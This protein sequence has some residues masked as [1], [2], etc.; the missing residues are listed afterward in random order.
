MIAYLHGT[1]NYKSALI[2][3]DNFAVI[4]VG[5]VGYKVYI[6]DRTLNGWHLGDTVE[7]HV[8]TQVGEDVLDL[9]GFATRDEMDWF[10]LLIGISGIGPRSAL[11]ILQ[12]AKIDDL[13]SGVQSGNYELLATVSGLG[14]K[15]AQKIVIG[16]KDKVGSIDA[17]VGWDNQSSDALEALIGLGYQPAQA[18]D[19]LQQVTA[20]DTGEQVKEALKILGQQR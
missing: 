15:V 5:G 11:G 1:I 2:K 10:G 8:H 17:V 12:K 14:P 3:K 7:A 6:L 13:R 4:V 18:R 19:A 16:L 9:Y 20:T